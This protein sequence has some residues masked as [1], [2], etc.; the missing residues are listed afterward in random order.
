VTP[1]RACPVCDGTAVDRLHHQRFALEADH[2][3]AGGYDVVACPRCGFVYADTGV[4]QAVYDRY[5]AELSK[6]EDTTTT[7]GAGDTPWDA[8]RLRGAARDVARPLAPGARILDLGCANGGLLRELRA[9]GFDDVAG[10]DPSP[11]CVRATREVVGVRAEEGS[12][13][14]VPA[15]LGTFDGVVLSHVMEH[16]EDLD[17]AVG[18]LVALL[19]PGGT[20]YVETPDA[21][22]YDAFLVAPFQD[23]NTEH[24]NH[25][26]PQSLRN[27][28]GRHGLVPV[29]EGRK[30]FDSG[31]GRPYGALY[32]SFRVGD[33]PPLRP[34][35]ELRPAVERYVERSQALLDAVD[36]R[37]RAVLDRAPEVVVWGTGQLALK[38]LAETVLGQARIAAFFDGNPINH[39]RTLR[40]VPV[41]A[42]EAARDYDQPIVITSTIHQGE[43]ERRIREELRLPNEVV[44]LG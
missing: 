2:P 40:G 15:A 32:G 19:A 41:L 33:P 14:A 37:L 22:R 10:L 23:F 13:F 16:V 8:A 7:T 20:V 24:I 43:I 31:P 1:R 18:K 38:L 42:P 44:L 39:G 12:L 21:S 29:D 27:L 4:P 28:M 5:Y 26:A 11:A 34:D 35:T 6:Y 36:G 3:L 30:E 9:L 17:D 25:F